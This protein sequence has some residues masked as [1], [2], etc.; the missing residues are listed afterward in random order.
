VK[1]SFGASA[2]A[3]LKNQKNEIIAEPEELYSTHMERKNPGRICKK[4]CTGEDIQDVIT[5]ANLGD[6]RLRNFSVA[7]GQIL[8]FSIGFRSRP[9]NTLALP[10]ECVIRKIVS[11][12]YSSVRL[13][14]FSIFASQ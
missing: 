13:A 11:Y 3:S 2:V 10:C 12:Q 14:N 6:D 9:Y 1:I 8:V 4:F 5:N 7:R